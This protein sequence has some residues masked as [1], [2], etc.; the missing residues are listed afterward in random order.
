[1]G[2]L[3]SS[4]IEAKV[5][6]VAAFYELEQMMSA[7]STLGTD[8]KQFTA[9]TG[10]S[11][12]VMQQY[13]WAAVQVGDANTDMM[14]TFKGL[15]DQ[16]AQML[17]GKGN[18]QYLA[19]MI[20]ALHE[21]GHLDIGQDEVK[22]WATDSALLGKR[23]QQFADLKGILPAF[24]NMILD[25]FHLSD[26]FKAD[27]ARGAFEPGKLAKAPTYS[28]SDVDNLN[29]A[30][31]AWKNM[32]FNID[33]AV[34]KFNALHGAK[35]AGEIE[36]IV[37][38]IL[39]LADSLDK[40][41]EKVKV[42]KLIGKSLE[43]WDLILE[44]INKT[45]PPNDIVQEPAGTGVVKKR[46]DEAVRAITGSTGLTPYAKMRLRQME[47]GGQM[48]VNQNTTQNLHFQHPGVDHQKTADSV[49]KAAAQA[50]YQTPTLARSS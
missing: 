15:Q 35:L 42:F 23:L 46:W 16:I 26:A 36:K 44:K 41:A 7:S 10:M 14:G 32:A 48:I 6:I 38:Q 18:P 25:S 20:K 43:G 5:A 50:H 27:L 31:I 3:W 24:R 34:G 21:K 19:L 49:K 37:K 22:K 11:A 33:M 12:K 29:R 1:M 2:D 45:S 28:G 4:S 9:L 40:L 8:L 39:V 30:D 47:A 17:A 13:K